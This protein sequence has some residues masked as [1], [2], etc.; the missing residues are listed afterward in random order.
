MKLRKVFVTGAAAA[1]FVSSTLHVSAAEVISGNY[2]KELKENQKLIIDVEAYKAAYSDLEQ[3]FGDDLDAYVEHYLTIGVYEGRTKGV[4]FDPLVY[5]ESY[6]DVKDAFG[7][8]IQAIVNHYLTFGVAE[9]RT[10]GTA[11]G[12]SDIAAAERA[13]VQKVQIQ[14]NLAAASKYDNNTI[15]NGSETTAVANTVADRSNGNTGSTAVVSNGNAL[16]NVLPS[17][18]VATANGNTP[19]VNTT[20][21]TI[22]HTTANKG[23]APAGNQAVKDDNSSPVVNSTTAGNSNVPAVNDGVSGSNSNAAPVNNGDASSGSSNASIDKG[24]HH[25]TSIYDN[26]ESTLLRVEYYDDNNKLIQYSSVSNFDSSTNSYTEQIYHYDKETESSVLD[27][28]D[29]YVNGVL[30]S[31]ENH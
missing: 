22:N 14:R 2:V 18:N 10:M 15:S 11:G 25:T 5:A 30:S 17:N 29:T 13:G 9:K 19:G 4:L 23:A 7:Y 16:N 3:S 24:Y 1:L 31:S 12:Y 20:A 27:R 28:T 21:P 8:N 6:S 26:D